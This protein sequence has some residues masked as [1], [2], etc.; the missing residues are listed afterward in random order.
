MKIIEKVKIPSAKL[1][2]NKFLYVTMNVLNSY[3]E[4]IQKLR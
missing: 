4:F 3:M 2:W 1:I